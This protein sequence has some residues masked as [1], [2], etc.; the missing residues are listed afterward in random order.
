M[1]QRLSYSERERLEREK[2]GKRSWNSMDFYDVWLG[3]LHYLS[4]KKIALPVDLRRLHGAI[5]VLCN[6]PEYSDL[7]AGW[8]EAF[9]DR[10]FGKYCEGIDGLMMSFQMSELLYC[11]FDDQFYVFLPKLNVSWKKGNIDKFFTES[12]LALLEQMATDLAANL[13]KMA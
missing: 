9:E 1:Y 2:N 8:T 13:K 4:V 3:I 10:I 11:D 6:K 7:V 5:Y 12:E